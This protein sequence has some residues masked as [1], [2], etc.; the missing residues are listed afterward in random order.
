MKKVILFVM[1]MS[2]LNASYCSICERDRE[3]LRCLVY[4]KE[5][6][7]KKLH[8]KLHN[9][10]L[11]LQYETKQNIKLR[12]ELE[13][14]KNAS[15][16]KSVSYGRQMQENYR[17]QQALKRERA[18]EN[19]KPTKEQLRSKSYQKNLIWY[20]RRFE[21]CKASLEVL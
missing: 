15:S 4:D 16:R 7:I 10:E 5:Q 14:V 13:R 11:Q 3:R 12:N 19:R 1:T 21:E 9:M 8:K 17:V 6:E 20:K 18:I 2:M